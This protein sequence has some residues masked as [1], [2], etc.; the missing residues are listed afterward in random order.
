LGQRMSEN[1]GKKIFKPKI[2][3]SA[4]SSKVCGIALQRLAIFSSDS[5]KFLKNEG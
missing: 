1:R 3:Q 2:K 5:L 4:G